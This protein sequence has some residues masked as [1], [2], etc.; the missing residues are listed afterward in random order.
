MSENKTGCCGLQCPL[1]SICEHNYN[2]QYRYYYGVKAFFMADYDAESK[3][4][5]NFK[6][7]EKENN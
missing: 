3:K 7:L 2:Y 4:C 5:R 1:K 6:Y